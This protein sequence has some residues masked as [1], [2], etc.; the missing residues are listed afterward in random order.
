MIIAPAEG[1]FAAALTKGAA[2]SGWATA[3]A[4]TG[5][6]PADVP[7][8]GG[9]VHGE[10]RFPWNPGSYVS[11]GALGLNLDAAFGNPDTLVLVCDPATTDRS[12]FDASPG[13]VGSALEAAVQGP[14]FLVREFLRRL[15][16]RKTGRIILVSVEASA[17]NGAAAPG[18]GAYASLVSSAFRGLG[19]GLFD[20]ARGATWSAW[21]IVDRGDKPEASADFVLRL[22]EEQK[23]AKSGRWLTFNGKAGI[24]GVF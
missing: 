23:T 2:A 4:A 10:L 12:L 17:G 3:L 16:A 15:E 13:G 7:P 9:A 20:R 21:G 11:A 18:A 5:P 22:L 8:D 14:V 19:E 1:D 6:V 24:F